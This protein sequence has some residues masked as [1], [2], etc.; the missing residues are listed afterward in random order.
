MEV[1]KDLPNFVLDSHRLRPDWMLQGG[2]TDSAQPS[3]RESPRSVHSMPSGLSSNGSALP[4][5]RTRG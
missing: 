5:V 1:L 4:Q 3:P 2:D